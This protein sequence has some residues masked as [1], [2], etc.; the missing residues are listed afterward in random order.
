MRVGQLGLGELLV[1]V[2]EVVADRRVDPERVAGLEAVVDHRRGQLALLRHLDLLLDHRSDDQ[3]VVRRQ[4]LR[5]RVVEVDLV[6]VDLE[7]VELLVDEALRGL[8]LREWIGRREQEA[9]E[10]RRVLGVVISEVEALGRRVRRLHVVAL[11]LVLH[12]IGDLRAREPLDDQQVL[13]LHRRRRFRRR[14]V[15]L[16]EL[17]DHL[18]HPEHEQ[19]DEHEE[20]ERADD[21]AVAKRRRG[22]AARRSARR[23]RGSWLR[24]R[25][26]RLGRRG[27]RRSRR[28]LGR[29]GR[30]PHFVAQRLLAAAAASLALGAPALALDRLGVLGE[31]VVP[32]GFV[33]HGP[34]FLDA[35]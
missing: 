32:L 4:V 11:D 10:A 13:G 35:R 31:R 34:A 14:G 27:R 25:L 6:E 1:V 28:L 23:R 22:R 9:L 26:R 21:A 30:L 12:L 24:R 7:L 16:G 2:V 3:H 18:D 5:L 33:A 15:L 20:E 8:L 19:P 17:A 29:G